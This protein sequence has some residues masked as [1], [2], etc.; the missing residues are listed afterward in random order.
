MLNERFSDELSLHVF[1]LYIQ[2][3]SEIDDCKRATKKQ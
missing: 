3:K 2:I 1:A